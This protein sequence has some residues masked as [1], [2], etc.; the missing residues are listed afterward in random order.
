MVALVNFMNGGIGRA[1]RIILGVALIYVGLAMMGGTT[2]I[3]VAIIG[4]LP[5]A[6]GIWGHCILEPAVQS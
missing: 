5:I 1:L 6:L 2:G 3:I 4:L